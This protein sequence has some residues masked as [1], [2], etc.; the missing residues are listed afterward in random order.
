[1]GERTGAVKGITETGEERTLYCTI[2]FSRCSSGSN[3]A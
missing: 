1:M 2:E 3:P